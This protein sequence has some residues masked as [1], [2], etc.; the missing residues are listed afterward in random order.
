MCSC[1]QVII[2]V[3]SYKKMRQVTDV[4]IAN[5]AASDIILL[6]T[7]PT[8]IVTRIT[9]HW[10]L[11]SVLCKAVT[12]IQV[13]MASVSILTMTLISIDRYLTIKNVQ[14]R[15]FT[16]L[17]AGIAIIVIWVVSCCVWI[18]IIIINIVRDITIHGVTF[19]FCYI[20]IHQLVLKY[21]VALLLIL[22]ILIVPLI[23]ITVNYVRVW[24]IA[25]TSSS[26]FNQSNNKNL[27]L[28][29]MLTAI[30]VMHII[31]YTPY[32]ISVFF[33][34]GTKLVT[35]TIYT[36]C[37]LCVFLG[38]V[39]NPIIYGYFNDKYR[40]V[41][42]QVILCQCKHNKVGVSSS[43]RNGTRREEQQ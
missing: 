17:H 15:K 20:Q 28:A 41:F 38:P 36:F 11:G 42:L 43:Q 1:F 18:M 40:R 19:I 14:G 5:L 25:K 30:V 24:R 2:C 33:I 13:S 26:R 12:Y 8:I 22:T 6:L 29:K 31:T 39:I 10:I 37:F 16:T 4:L 35:S 9:K 34:V 21:S 3:Y 23:V 27:E 32:C 7:I